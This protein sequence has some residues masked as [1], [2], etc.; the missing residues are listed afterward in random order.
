MRFFIASPDATGYID[1]P[2]RHVFESLPRVERWQDADCILV[3]VSRTD[4]YRFNE[5]LFQ[6]TDHKPWCLVDFSEFFWDNPQDISYIWGQNMLDFPW[7]NQNADWAK[8]DRFVR[9]RVPRMIWQRE[10]FN[11]D[12]TDQIRPIEWLCD[13]EPARP[14]SKD[15]F[16]GRPMEWLHNWG[17]SNESRVLFH[18][19][20][21][22]WSSHLGYDAIGSFDHIEEYV[23]RGMKFAA[24]VHV[25]DT[26]RIDISRVLQYQRLAKVST[27]FSGCGVCCF[28]HVEAPVNSIMAIQRNRKA[29]TYPWVDGVNCLELDLGIGN[30]CTDGVY[31][32]DEGDPYM[33][34]LYNFLQRD[35]LHEI[36]A[37]GLETCRLYRP[38]QFLNNH[39]I[40]TIAAKL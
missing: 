11:A 15:E 26:K 25:P 36:Y 32:Q 4:R 39:F 21:F 38:S 5:G 29:W 31:F 33:M 6:M 16:Y 19:K 40:P 17:R 1:P 27:S 9:E 35:D 3:L 8:F 28:R 18:A 10:L 24:A 7:W 37:N 30:Q 12:A 34:K 14:Q 2:I 20:T 22:E 13:H 23:K